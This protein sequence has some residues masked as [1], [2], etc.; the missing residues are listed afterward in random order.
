MTNF[1]FYCQSIEPYPLLTKEEENKL[2]KIIQKGKKQIDKDKAIQ[3]LIEG[4]LRLVIRAALDYYN[5]FSNVRKYVDVMDLISEG[6]IVIMR[7][8][9]TFNSKKGKFSTFAL[10][11]MEN[12]FKRIIDLCRF[13]RIPS[14]HFK[15]WKRVEELKKKRGKNLN[16]EQM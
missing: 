6:N 3:K 9:K 14:G 12:H 16:S 13:I 5:R 15:Y 2:S 7:A 4:N 10:S 1:E 8:A 11:I